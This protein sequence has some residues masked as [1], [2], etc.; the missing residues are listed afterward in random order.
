MSFP[1]WFVAY[2]AGLACLFLS[3]T[4]GKTD[5][6]VGLFGLS[7]AAGVI[8]FVLDRLVSR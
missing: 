4:V 5:V 8:G 3:M 7:L 1:F 2:L 6:T